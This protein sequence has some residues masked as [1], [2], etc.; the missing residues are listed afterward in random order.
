MLKE[1]IVSTKEAEKEV[2]TT[3]TYLKLHINESN[4]AVEMKRY[5]KSYKEE[6]GIES[7]LRRLSQVIFNLKNE[8]KTELY[9]FKSAVSAECLKIRCKQIEDRMKKEFSDEEDFGEDD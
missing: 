7:N 5:I 6:L 2:Q 4:K 1:S 9:N 8:S 3:I